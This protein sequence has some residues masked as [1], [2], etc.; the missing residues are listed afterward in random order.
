MSGN[1]SESPSGGETF[2]GRLQRARDGS[3]DA[4]GELVQSC[5]DYLLMV[6]NQ[7]M[8]DHLRGKFGASDAV[9][10]TLAAAHRCFDQFRGA[11]HEEL[12]GW[13]RTILRNHLLMAHR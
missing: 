5:R 3:G 6:A 4:M 11:T 13:L 10:E 9:Q 8:G 1:H 12:V 2:Q 7:D